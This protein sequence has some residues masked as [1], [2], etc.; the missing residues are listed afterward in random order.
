MDGNV[1]LWDATRVENFRNAHIS[2]K[3]ANA[4]FHVRFQEIVSA[5]R[6]EDLDILASDLTDKL[7]Q[8]IECSKALVRM[9]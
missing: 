3:Q 9:E 4:S 7:D 8:F 1:Q 6:S 5:G 2:W